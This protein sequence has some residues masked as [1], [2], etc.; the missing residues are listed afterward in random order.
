MFTVLSALIV[1]TLMTF[2]AVL[3]NSWF[4]LTILL[5]SV[6]GASLLKDALQRS[7]WSYPLIFLFLAS[8]LLILLLPSRLA[9]GFVTGLFAWV[10]A[11]NGEK[12]T[13][14]FFKVLILIGILEG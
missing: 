4:V 6:I 12:Q 1:Y 7:A 5:L 11:G 3:P 13:L 2:G 10:A 14:R 9:V 8:I